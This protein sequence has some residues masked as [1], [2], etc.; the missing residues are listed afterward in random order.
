MVLTILLRDGLLAVAPLLI[1]MSWYFKYSFALLDDV[2]VGR[3]EAPVLSVEMIMASLGEFRSL[4]PLILVIVVFFAGGAGRYF[5]GG[6]TRI[7][8]T[9]FPGGGGA[10]RSAFLQILP[11]Q[12]SRQGRRT[13]LRPVLAS[14]C[15]GLDGCAAAWDCRL[16]QSRPRSRS[17]TM[18]H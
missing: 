6:Q 9:Q 18:S 13:G 14:A 17:A 15:S 4:L 8:E 12:R 7:R 2:V 1:L 16:G 11:R 3:Y 10:E 5:I